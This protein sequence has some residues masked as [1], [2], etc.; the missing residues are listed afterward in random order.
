M[1]LTVCLIFK[2]T[3]VVVVILVFGVEAQQENE[4]LRE[5]GNIHH[6]QFRNIPNAHGSYSNDNCRLKCTVG[7][8]MLSEDAVN[9]GFPCPANMNGVSV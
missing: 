8:K 5:C 9:E 4:A 6:L 3:L 2:I 7:D 1:N